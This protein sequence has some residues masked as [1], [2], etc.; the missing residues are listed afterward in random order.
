MDFILLM[1]LPFITLGILIG[2]FIMV[3]RFDKKLHPK[4]FERLKKEREDK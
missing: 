4:K 3:Y 2:L 1:T